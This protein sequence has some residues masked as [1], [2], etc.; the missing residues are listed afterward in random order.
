MARATW[1]QSNFNGGEWSPLAH[2]RFDLAPYRKAMELCSNFMPTQQ[3]GLTRRPGAPYVAAVKDSTYAPRLIPFMF[4]TSQAYI[5]EFGELYIRIYINDGQL[6]AT[7]IPVYSSSKNYYAGNLVS[8]SGIVYCCIATVDASVHPP[9]NLTYWIPS[10]TVVTAWNASATYSAG[11]RVQRLGIYYCCLNTAHGL[12]DVPT[13]SGDGF[14]WI[15]TGTTIEEFTASGSYTP[16]DIVSYLGVNYYCTAAPSAAP[17]NTAYWYALTGAIVEI[18]TPYSRFDVWM[19]DFDT[20]ADTI[21]L[22]HPNHPVMKLQRLGATKWTLTNVAFL[23]GPYLTTNTTT[24]TLTP[25]GTSGAVT[26]TASAV[27]G[28]NGGLGFSAADVGRTLRIKCGGVWLWGAI[29]AYTSPTVVTW[30]ITNPNGQMVPKTAAGTANVS[31]GS[32]FSVSVTDGGGGYGVSPPAV[33]FTGGGG[34]GAVAYA[35]LSNGVVVAVTMSVTGTGYTSAPTVIF[36]P[37]AGIVASSTSFW[38]LGVWNATDGYPSVVKFHQ[39]RLCFAGNAA[40]PGR[41]DASN[42]S[43]YENFA[44]TNI[45]GTVVDSNAFSF[46]LNESLNAIQWM[47][48]DKQ[49]LLCGTGGGEWVIAPSG[50]QQAITPTNINIKSIGGYGSAFVKPVRIGNVTLFV[51]RTTRKLRELIYQFAYDT[52]T[53]VDV[54]LVAEHLTK[55]GLKQAAV[56]FA[57]YQ[58]VWIVRTDG[59]LVGMTYDRDQEVNGWHRH[60][61]GGYSDAA[62]TQPPLVE[63]VACIPAPNTQRDEVWLVVN[64]YINGATVRTVERMAKVWEDGDALADAVFLDSSATY[65]G[66]A[67][68]TVSGLTWLKGQTV[69]VLTDGSV[70]PDC[71]VSNTGT[72]TLNWAATKV[73]VGLGYASQGKT[74]RVE[75]GGADGP[76]QGKLKRIMWTIFRFFQTSKFDLWSDTVGVGYES[77]AFRDSNDPMT[78]AVSLFNGD[79]RW[80]YDGAWAS[81][82]QIAFQAS[83]PLPCNV[84]LLMAQVDT[85]E[86]Q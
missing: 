28:I 40:N 72:I 67:T 50:T 4:S 2:G 86:M 71:V 73:Q 79:K 81:D 54:S 57:P 29:T 35:T 31:S 25:S 26:V 82:G 39:D 77:K 69:S 62:Q 64:R 49:G 11:D 9:P 15:A 20:K 5:L 21:Y 47:T 30:T 51:Q 3:G 23:D 10:T 6:Q 55:G 80:T 78:T 68:T 8:S 76:S 85:K 48:S 7:G 84:T 38:R 66:V 74:L 70:H 44:P 37:P 58:I 52:F 59:T 16:G 75:A 42:T 24:T 27:A 45:D 12:T 83:G 1:V 18:P 14:T 63:S 61:L 56:Q 53:N 33:S 60:A 13:G 65:S 46:T 34:S 43:D 32:V 22:A 36:A 41:I 17:P 19:L